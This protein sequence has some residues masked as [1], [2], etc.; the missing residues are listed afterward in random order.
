MQVKI[1]YHHTDCGGVVYYARYL[2]FFEEARTECLAQKGVSVHDL[3]SG[4]TFFVVAHQDIDY[5]CPAVYGDML[6]V[7][8]QISEVSRAKIIFFCEIKNQKGQL[9]AM[10]KTVMV[11]VDKS[12]K[13]QALPEEAHSKISQ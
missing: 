1:H 6:T 5:K 2:D 12:L 9:I 4:G 7:T 13:P 8:A 11:C 3:A 10:G